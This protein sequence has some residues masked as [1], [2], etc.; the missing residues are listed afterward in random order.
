VVL[1]A[2]ALLVFI[3][4]A[5]LRSSLVIGAPLLVL[6]QLAFVLEA[7]DTF[8]A[9]WMGIE[10]VPLR[11]DDL[12]LVFGYAFAIV[13]IL[14]GFYSFHVRSAGQHAAALAYGGS[15]LGAVFAGDLLTLVLAWEV[16]A[17]ASTYLVL[18]GERPN[19][20]EAG[21]RYL[22]VHL[23]GGTVLL[24]GVLWHAGDTGSLAFE[25]FSGS[26]AAWLILLGFGINAAIPPL[27]AWLADAYPEASI[28]GTIFLSA[29][30]TK[31]AVYVLARGFAGWEI[32]VALGAMM[33]LYGVVYAVLENDTR[34][35]LSYHII[36]QVGFM[37]AAVGIGTDTAIN[38]A[39]AHAFA[40]ILYKGLMLMSVGAILY[41]TGKSRM[42]ELGGLG[43]RA[44]QS[45]FLLYMVGGLAISA[46]PL[47]S[48]FTTKGLV[49]ESAGE[50]H[51]QWVVL[52]LYVASVGTFLS[53]G[54]KLPYFTWFGRPAASPP[55]ESSVPPGMYVAM[56]GAAI[57]CIALGVYPA[58]LYDLL[59][60]PVDYQAYT[61][62]HIVHTLQLLGFTGLAFWL[63]RAKLRPKAKISLDT[64]WFYRRAAL[65]LG[66]FVMTPFEQV[67]D[68]AQR[69]F[70]Q[71]TAFVLETGSA[72]DA[73][74]RSFRRAAGIA[75]PIS[76]LLL[77]SGVLLLLS[78]VW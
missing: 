31:T 34:R 22:Y 2:A 32:L 33:A 63:L 35:L 55:A 61:A 48:G 15:A 14:G 8:E 28:P 10:I 4:P 50:A 21:I 24:G 23:I 44:M 45:L 70:N 58:P 68:G 57:F 11:V 71:A 6:A 41:A 64:D 77:V 46:L 29:F 19:S 12:S 27:H 65:P 1:I 72:G 54:L 26:A 53:T 67:F 38:A 62:S 25:E 43:G 59:P 39:A 47:F 60:Y 9:T 36:S 49:I 16:M 74:M 78:A 13:A 56:I 17:V 52:L 37:V 75:A 5:R 7:G 42:T 69:Q 66:R 40:H 73:R 3:V 20:R 51:K 18:A 76:L 30:T